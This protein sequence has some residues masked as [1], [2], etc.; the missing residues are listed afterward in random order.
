MISPPL[1]VFIYRINISLELVASLHFIKTEQKKNRV[2]QT[3]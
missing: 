3:G 1:Q 2:N